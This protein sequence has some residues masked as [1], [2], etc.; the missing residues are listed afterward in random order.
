MVEL[1]VGHS[2]SSNNESV[3]VWLRSSRELYVRVEGRRGG[4]KV[5]VHRTEELRRQKAEGGW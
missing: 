4:S 2:S 5:G 3:T 1:V